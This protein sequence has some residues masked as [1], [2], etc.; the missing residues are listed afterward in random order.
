MTQCPARRFSRVVRRAALQA[1]T[2]H[3]RILPLRLFYRGIQ[4]R[5]HSKMAKGSKTDDIPEHPPSVEEDLYEILGVKSDA[6]PEA[7]KSA[8]KKSALKNHPG[9]SP[10]I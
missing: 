7:V 4:L 3:F 8:Y 10:N 5:F 2:P 6:T 9:I 1:S